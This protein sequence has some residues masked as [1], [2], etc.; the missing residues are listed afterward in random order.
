MPKRTKERRGR[1]IKLIKKRILKK[2]HKI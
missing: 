1:K 2:L